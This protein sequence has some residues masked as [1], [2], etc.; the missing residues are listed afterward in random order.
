MAHIGVIQALEEAG[1]HFS[2]ISGTSA[3]AIVGALYAHGYTPKEIFGIVQQVSIFKTVRPA[4]AWTGLLK[5]DGMQ[6]LLLRYLPENDFS[7][8]KMPLTVAATEIRKGVIKYFSEGELIPAILASCSIPAVFSPIVFKESMYVDG[9]LLDNLPA[10][11]IRDACD[12]IIASN[13]NHVS[14]TFDPTNL[15]VM[16][17]RSLLVAINANTD[18]SKQLCDIVVEP[19][20][21]DKYSSFDIGKAKEIFDIGYKFTKENFKNSQFEKMV[22]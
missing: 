11:P 6:E 8:L 5:M 2:H 22:A 20:G 16:I 10:R 12:F 19:P 14:Q 1:L 21:L 4:W 9:G 15:K 17:E 3:G 18:I 7:Q 13:C